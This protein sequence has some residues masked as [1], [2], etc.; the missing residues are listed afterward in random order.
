MAVG[1]NGSGE[2]DTG[3]WGG[4]VKISGGHV[5]SFGIQS[6]GVPLVKGLNNYGQT[7]IDTWTDI[8]QIAAGDAHTVGLK[9]DGT[10]VATGYNAYGQCDVSTWYLGVT[11]IDGDGIPNL[12][13]N[14]PYVHNPDQTD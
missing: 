8:I 7:N 11:D 13:D 10:V 6:N 9:S 3:S 1:S 12:E 2:C 5:T 4:I 14:C